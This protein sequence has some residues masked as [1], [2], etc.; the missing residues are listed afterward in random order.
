MTVYYVGSEIVKEVIMT[1]H[2]L[3]IQFAAGYTEKLKVILS[4]FPDYRRKGKYL[5]R[6]Q[7]SGRRIV[8]YQLRVSVGAG[9]GNGTHSCHQAGR[10]E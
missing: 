1:L 8:A 9:C 4:S 6:H 7:I 3:N 10:D 5:D 2:H